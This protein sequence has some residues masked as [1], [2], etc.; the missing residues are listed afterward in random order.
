MYYLETKETI[1]DA[2]SLNSFKRMGTEQESSCKGKCNGPTLM[3]SLFDKHTRSVIGLGNII[4]VNPIKAIHH[5]PLNGE[6]HGRN[7]YEN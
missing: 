5:K 7:G 6:D 3:P 1:L 4:F 2:S